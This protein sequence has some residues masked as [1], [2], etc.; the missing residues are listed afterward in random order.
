MEA[1]GLRYRQSGLNH[2]LFNI[3]GQYCTTKYNP[4]VGTNWHKNNRRNIGKK[5]AEIEQWKIEVRSAFK[6]KTRKEAA[7]NPIMMGEEIM[8][9]EINEEENYRGHQIHIGGSDASIMSTIN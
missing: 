3:S 9:E 8:E 7:T 4:G 6:E 2:K 1:F 5:T